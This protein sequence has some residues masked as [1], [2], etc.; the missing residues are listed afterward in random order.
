MIESSFEKIPSSFFVL[1]L[2]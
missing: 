2:L 1:M